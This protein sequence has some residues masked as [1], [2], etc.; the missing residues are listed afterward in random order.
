MAILS[1]ACLLCI[2]YFFQFTLFVY[3]DN[4]DGDVAVLRDEDVRIDITS[5]GPI[6][7]SG[8]SNISIDISIE[9]YKYNRDEEYYVKIFRYCNADR[10]MNGWMCYGLMILLRCL[11][12]CIVG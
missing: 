11:L 8:A 6:S 5:F 7:L 9:L 12:R 4:R 3:G 2:L 1:S 10:W